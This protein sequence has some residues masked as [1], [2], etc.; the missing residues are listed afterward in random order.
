M[1]LFIALLGGKPADST[2]E[3]HNVFFGIGRSMSS[4]FPAIKK[5][6]PSAPKIHIDAYIEINRIDGYTIDIIK[7]NEAKEKDIAL[8]YQT[9]LF[10]INLGGYDERVFDEKHK[11]L[12]LVATDE[13]EACRQAKNDPFFKNSYSKGNAAPHIDDRKTLDEFEEDTPIDIGE[14]VAKQGYIIVPRLLPMPT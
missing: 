13:I 12:L 9:K 2:I 11:R 10:F 4:L 6:W 5:F 7:K 3:A 14:V 1:K 8:A